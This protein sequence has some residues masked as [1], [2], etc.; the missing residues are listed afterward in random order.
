MAKGFGPRAERLAAR[1]PQYLGIIVTDPQSAVTAQPVIADSHMQGQPCLLAFSLE[2]HLCGLSRRIANVILSQSADY[3]QWCDLLDHFAAGTMQINAQPLGRFVAFTEQN[4]ASMRIAAR[5]ASAVVVQT[6]REYESLTKLDVPIRRVVRFVAPDPSVPAVRAAMGDAIVVWAPDRAPEELLIPAIALEELKAPL[7]IVCNRSATRSGL[8][9]KFIEHSAAAGVLEGARIIVDYTADAGT[10]LSLSRVGLPMA[11]PVQGGAYE[12]LDHVATFTQWD[13][14]SIA[15][16]AQI[17]MARPAASARDG[18]PDDPAVL[19]RICGEERPRPE[20]GGPLVS[21]VIPTFNRPDML[22]HA[23]AAARAQSYRNVEIVVV[24]DGGTPVDGVVAGFPGVR[25]VNSPKNLGLPGAFNLGASAARGEYLF[26][27]C[28]DDDLPRNAIA[29][30]VAATATN[31]VEFVHGD[32]INE[33]QQQ[34]GAGYRRMGYIC[35]SVASMDRSHALVHDSIGF[36]CCLFRKDLWEELGGLDLRKPYSSD[37]DFLIRAAERYEFAHVD[38][39]VYLRSVRNDGS[40]LGADRSID[41]ASVYLDL[42]AHHPVDGRPVL[43]ARRKQRL[44]SLQ[45]ACDAPPPRPAE[46]IPR[47]EPPDTTR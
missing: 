45:A 3:D 6:W 13:R 22:A 11:V 43:A 14:R 37:N 30:L 17:A 1:F 34:E 16:S 35:N 12:Y 42:C 19:K 18:I 2:E 25:L 46:E 31:R 39:P 36:G 15:Q 21:I 28:D 38:T 41:S 26:F 44:E 40:H 20:D 32:A 5:F 24:N 33:L 9:A 10:A 23:V 7:F 47:C 27:L 29:S 8:R 4:V